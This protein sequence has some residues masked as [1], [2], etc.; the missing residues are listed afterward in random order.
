[1]FYQ[2]TLM[3]RI[4]SKGV[5]T[6]SVHMR[7]SM[8][9]CMCFNNTSFRMLTADTLAEQLAEFATKLELVSFVQS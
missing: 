5:I 2:K 4:N 3:V 1:M 9:F 7:Q 6:Y 8:F